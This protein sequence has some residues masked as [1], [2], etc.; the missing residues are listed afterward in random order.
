MSTIE[1]P[2]YTII[3]VASDSEPYNEMQLKL[4]LGELIN[5]KFIHNTIKYKRWKGGITFPIYCMFLTIPTN[6]ST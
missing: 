2:C 5:D 6:V 1:Q 4:D 3:N